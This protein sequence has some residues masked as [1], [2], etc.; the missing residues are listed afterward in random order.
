MIKFIKYSFLCLLLVNNL[1]HAELEI[2]ISEGVDSARPVAIVPFAVEGGK[3]SYDFAKIISDD[4]RNSG[5]FRPIKPADM[6]QTPSSSDDVDFKQW[7]A[8]GAEVVVVGKVQVKPDGSY[9]VNYELLDVLQG[10]VLKQNKQHAAGNA[11]PMA[12]ND[13]YILSSGHRDL[14]KNQ[15]RQYA[16]LISDTIFSRLTGER[17]AFLTRISYVVVDYA[18]KYPYQLKVADYD[19]F[20]ESTLVKSKE[21]LMSPSW[22]P[23]AQNLAYVSFEN[24]KAEIFIQNIYTQKRQ[25]LTSF[26]GINGAPRWSPDGKKMAIVLSKDGAPNVYVIDIKSKKLKKITS[27]RSI[28]TEPFWSPDGN[29]LIFSSERGGKPQIYQVNLSTGKIGRLT[30]DGDLNLGGTFTPDG[31]QLIMVS[32]SQGQYR[33]ARQDLRNDAFQV[34]TRTS[35]DESPTIAPNGSMI[36][37]STVSNNRQVLA[38]VS[39]DGR[40]KATLPVKKGDV[41]APAWSPFLN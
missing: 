2:I 8:L 31:R 14:K 9:K 3:A 16:H 36:M 38:L 13:A 28:D 34:L 32:R 29:Y 21:P 39:M 4:L 30:W 23:D 22:S 5:R 17:G 40:F 37:Y 35:L 7:S 10:T 20:A 26:T 11:S 18:K 25:K 41:R 12:M 6:P 1:A 19:G 27:T 15:L 24:K 33:I